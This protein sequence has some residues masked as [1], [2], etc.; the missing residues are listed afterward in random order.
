MG[1]ECCRSAMELIKMRVCICMVTVR[2]RGRGKGDREPGCKTP[3]GAV[4]QEGVPCTY[5][6]WVVNAATATLSP[7]VVSFILCMMGLSQAACSLLSVRNVFDRGALARA[8][9]R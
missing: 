7:L 6:R 3:K 2:Q 1:V 5:L 9:V 4:R 8:P